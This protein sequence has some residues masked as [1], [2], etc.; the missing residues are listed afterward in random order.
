MSATKRGKIKADRK[1]ACDDCPWRRSN[2]GRKTKGGWYTKKNIRRLWAGLR[3]GDAPGMTCHPTDADHDTEDGSQAVPDGTQAKECYGSLLLV[4]REMNS[5]SGLCET[6]AAGQG[7]KLYKSLRPKGL[8]RYGLMHWTERFMLGH[9]IFGGNIP[10][11][12]TFDE[13]ADIQHPDFDA[14]ETD[15][16]A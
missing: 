3:S 12:R 9:T 10:L 1:V 11:P 16:D 14:P 6:A 7:F 2:A 4:G 15:F 5:F 13:D 8:T